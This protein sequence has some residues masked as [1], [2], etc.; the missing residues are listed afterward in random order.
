MVQNDI[1]NFEYRINK[2]LNIKKEKES[3]D[4]IKTTNL[5]DNNNYIQY[6]PEVIQNEIKKGKRRERERE[7]ERK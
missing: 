7:R 3:K 1:Y 6:N 4:N 2:E 5:N